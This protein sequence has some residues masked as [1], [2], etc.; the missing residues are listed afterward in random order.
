[1]DVNSMYM[2]LRYAQRQMIAA[3]GTKAHSTWKAIVRELDA[4]IRALTVCET[5][6]ASA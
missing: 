2:K 3:A 1:M 4:N 5:V 6:S